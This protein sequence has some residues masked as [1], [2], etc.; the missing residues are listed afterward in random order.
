MTT[1]IDTAQLGQLLVESA[2]KPRDRIAAQALAEEETILALPQVR[3]LLVVEDEGRPTARWE[4][5]M[6][7]LYTLQLD[8]TQRAFLALVL[9]MLGI[10][11]ITLAAVEDLD[12]RRL[13][14]MQRAILKLAGNDRIAVGTRL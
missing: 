10:G 3:S 1:I 14:I 9:S 2:T 12:E 5:L 11:Q 13:L 7:R 6:G 4:K 8:A